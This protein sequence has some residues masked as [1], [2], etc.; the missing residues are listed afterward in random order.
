MM[1]VMGT[2]EVLLQLDEVDVKKIFLT[3]RI[4]LHP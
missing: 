4:Q 2:S 1:C 3:F